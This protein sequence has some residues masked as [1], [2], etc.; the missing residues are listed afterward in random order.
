MKKIY[1][2]GEVCWVDDRG[3]NHREGAPA[4]IHRSGTAEWYHDGIFARDASLGPASIGPNGIKLWKKGDTL[5][6]GSSSMYKD[7]G[8]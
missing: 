2:I 7:H 1:A 4:V 8:P 5:L 6:L 3:R